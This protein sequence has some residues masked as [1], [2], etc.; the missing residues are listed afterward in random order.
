MW[1]LVETALW[2]PSSGGRRSSVHG[3]G[4]VHAVVELREG[5]RGL[6]HL[7]GHYPQPLRRE[8]G[9]DRRWPSN[10]PGR[11][12]LVP[13]QS[14]CE[15]NP[16]PAARIAA[17]SS[18]V[19]AR[20]GQPRGGCRAPAYV[21]SKGR[22]QVRRYGRTRSGDVVSNSSMTS[23]DRSDAAEGYHAGRL[24][25]RDDRRRVSPAA[26]AALS[27]IRTQFPA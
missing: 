23:A 14:P 27:N 3:C 2:F 6:H 8:A 10:C 11:S 21:R 4:S 22:G 26:F 15:S 5:V 18:Y 1:A 24:P 12:G 19:P 17:I 25:Q 9:A 20:H 13:C 7:T 16:V